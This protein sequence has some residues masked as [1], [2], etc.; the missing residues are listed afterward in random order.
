MMNTTGVVVTE[1]FAA[2]GD[3]SIMALLGAARLDVADELPCRNV[4]P[5]AFFAESPADVEWAKALCG[6]CP[7]KQRCLAGAQ[8]RREPWGVWGGELFINGVVVARKRPRGRPRKHPLPGEAPAAPKPVP[9]PPAVELESEDD[10][11]A[12]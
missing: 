7:V 9:V 1:A 12:A 6:D 8:E 3:T 11:S 5:E 10:Q 2:A 4:D